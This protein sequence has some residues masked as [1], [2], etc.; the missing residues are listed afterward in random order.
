MT[1]REQVC[2]IATLMRRQLTDVSMV[3]SNAGALTVAPISHLR[4]EGVTK[5]IEINLLAHFWVSKSHMLT[6]NMADRMGPY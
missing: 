6:D 4:P 5:H 2:A 1:A 3:V